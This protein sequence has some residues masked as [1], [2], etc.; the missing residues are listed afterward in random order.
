MAATRKPA[1][2]EMFDGKT[3]RQ[4]MWEAIRADRTSFT[5][6]RIACRSG[7]EEVAVCAYLRGLRRAGFIAPLREYAK[8]ERPSYHLVRD[9]GSEA[10][11]VNEKGEKTT[12]GKVT[13]GLW[14]TLRIMG[15]VTTVQAAALASAGGFS[16]SPYT[17]E[18]YFSA[19]RRAGY[20]D[21]IKPGCYRLRLSR[22]TGPRPLIVQKRLGRQVY[23]PNIDQ[24]VWSPDSGKAVA[25]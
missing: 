2:L 5:R 21:R 10:P 11:R 7:Q 9:N 25:K 20:V 12:G 22:N 13:E 8:M 23:D 14:R 19:L 15:E 16:V 3:P 1:H 6:F 18:R 4:R 17:A 24:V